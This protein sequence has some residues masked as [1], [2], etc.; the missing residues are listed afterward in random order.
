MTNITT[1]NCG[2]E[3]PEDTDVNIQCFKCGPPPKTGQRQQYPGRF[4]LNVRK[5]YPQVVS[6]K[7]LHM[8]SG[9]SDFGITTDFRPETGADYICSFDAIPLPDNS[10]SNVIADPPYNDAWQSQDWKHDDCPKPKHIL[11][12]AQRLVRPG[13]LILILH[14]IIIPD[15]SEYIDISRIGIHP[16]LAGPNNAIRALNVFRKDKFP[17]PWKGQQ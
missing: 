2:P 7:T 17:D 15:Y 9:A 10:V 13:G 16:I 14:I 1:W 12:E 4:M 8:F 3:L 5:Y 6:P 11:R